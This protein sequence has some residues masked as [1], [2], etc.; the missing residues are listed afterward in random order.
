MAVY[1]D[2]HPGLLGYG[3]GA[4]ESSLVSQLL[5][6][7]QRQLSTVCMSLLGWELQP[8][9]MPAVPSS[10]RWLCRRPELLCAAELACI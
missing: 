7:V 10:L 6:D 2:N 3:T 8:L 1:V 5:P 4:L 9:P